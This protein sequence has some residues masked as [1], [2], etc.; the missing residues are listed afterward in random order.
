MKP[1]N[2]KS[3]IAFLFNQME[4]LDEGKIDVQKAREQANLSKQVNNAMKYELDRAKV[5]ME[6]TKHNAIYKD[7]INLR[8]IESKNF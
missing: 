8:E 5:K 1:V 6:L 2:N 4:K 7:G 3:L